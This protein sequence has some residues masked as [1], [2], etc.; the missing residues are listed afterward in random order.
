[1]AV[2]VYIPTPY[3]KHTAQ[4]ARLRVEATTVRGVLDAL[5]AQFP[6]LKD[7]LLNG[8]GGIA[9]HLNIY[10]GESEVRTLA[11][12]ATPVADGTEVSLIPAMS[13]G[14][15]L[16]LSDEQMERYSRNILLK[17]VGVEGQKKLLRARVLLI[18]AGGLGSPAAV[19]LAAAGVGTIGIVDGDR[20][21]LTNLQ[22]QVLHFTHDVNRPKTQSARRHLEDLNPDVKVIPYQTV[23]T[24]ENA[25]DI[26][27]DWDI[28]INGC[29]NFP[30][31]YLVNDACVFLKKPLIDAAI[32][33]WEA[34]ATVFLPGQGCYRCLFP[35]PPPPGSVPTCAE[36]GIIGAMAGHLGTLQALEAVK[37]IL[38]VGETLGSK[39][40]LF[41]ALLTEYRVLRRQRNPE[42]P[43]CGDHPTVTELVDYNEFCGV[44]GHNQRPA[45]ELET[46][47]QPA[48]SV[49]GAAQAATA[50]AAVRSAWQDPQDSQVLPGQVAPFVNDP[51]V[52]W[53]DVRE[54]DEYGK[55]HIPGARLVPMSEINQRYREIDPAR[56][57]VLV[58]EIGARS[59]AVTQA[60]RRAGYQRAFNLKGG[61]MAWVNQELPVERG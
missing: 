49:T 10:V 44:P 60:L 5:V 20:V 19:Y 7:V 43:V 16:I 41:D 14:A 58:C 50:P 8:D 25:L 51:T 30:T 45:I 48:A 15:D 22:R 17:E 40:L 42:C 55:Y 21:D 53:V 37:L 9:D 1:M 18:G 24:S 54:P 26:L 6:E 47:P 13:G 36:A 2:Q 57:A 56:P 34:Q 4:Q 46:Q 38:G 32:L 3:R 28:I 39:L 61:M 31:R 23:L 33:M 35:S 11:G 12:E 52:Q 29:D 59:G 27:A